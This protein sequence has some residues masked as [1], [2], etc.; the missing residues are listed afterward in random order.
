M[1]TPQTP[2][3]VFVSYCQ[4]PPEHAVKV[5]EF[6]AQFRQ[7]PGITCVIDSDVT[8]PRGPECGWPQWMEDQIEAAD[9]VFVV[10]NESYQMRFRGKEAPGIGKGATWEGYI[11]TT[12]LYEAQCRNTKFIPVVFAEADL[13]FIPTTLNGYTHYSLPGDGD[14]L[15]HRLLGQPEQGTRFRAAIPRP[16]TTGVVMRYDRQGRDLTEVVEERLIAGHAVT[17]FGDGGRGKSTLAAAVARN[18][19]I[20]KGAI[21]W[22]SADGRANFSLG[23]WM[24][25]IGGQ[26][27]RPDIGTLPTKAKT[28][29]VQQLLAE[30]EA[31]PVLDNFET[32]PAEEQQAVAAFCRATETPILIT[33]RQPVADT[34]GVKVEALT[35]AEA[36]ELLQ[37]LMERSSRAGEPGWPEAVQAMAAQIKEISG[38]NALMLCW[39]VGQLAQAA[40]LEDVIYDLNHGE[41]DAAQRIFDRSFQLLNA[42]E[43][44]VVMG[45]S[46]FTPSAGREALAGVAGFGNDIHRLKATLKR[47]M[48]IHLLGAD[49]QN[50]RFFL[51]GLTRRLARARLEKDAAASAFKEHFI[52]VF[53][54]FAVSHQEESPEDFDSLESEKENLFSSMDLALEAEDWSGLM[55]V[56]SALTRFLGTRGYWEQAIRYGEQAL[57]AARNIGSEEAIAHFSHNTGVIYQWRGEF[58][59]AKRLYTESFKIMKKL[60]I[61]SGIATSLHQLGMIAQEQ[62]GLSEAKRLYTKSLKIEKKL[63]NQIGIADSLHQLGIVAQRQDDLPEAKRLYTKSFEIMKKLGNQNG[64]ATSLHQL[65]IIAQ[66]QDD[67]PEAKRIYMESLQIKKKLGNQ[68]GIAGSLHQLGMIA[69]MDGDRKAALAFYRDALGIF[70]RIQSPDATVTRRS[71]ARVESQPEG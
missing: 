1:S 21:S 46:L 44:A 9:W 28:Q 37:R 59:E 39:V 61:Q 66:L 33:G 34:C 3:K 5:Q 11:I 41:G 38:R 71:I 42:D 58:S 51:A 62:D 43:Q 30:N 69:E 63:G 67:L 48:A 14:L 23:D 2:L 56:R 64:I 25:E 53:R 20:R 10:C 22:V 19:R 17:L 68:S 40:R 65:G 54:G 31:L 16:P 26:L 49:A 27:G 15:Y 70:E 36:D 13:P 24:D 45:V 8:S 18:W 12:T 32:I 4:K 7:R 60:G 47:P 52:A 55:T 35:D 50:G 29:A 6:F 57:L